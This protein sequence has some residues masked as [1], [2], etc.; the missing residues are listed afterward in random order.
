MIR[1]DGVDWQWK[2]IVMIGRGTQI[3]GLALWNGENGYFS[4][5]TTEGPK[6][7][8]GIP[9]TWEPCACDF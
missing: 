1:L 3:P 8:I 6:W 9:S 5:M 7:A 4:W 2:S